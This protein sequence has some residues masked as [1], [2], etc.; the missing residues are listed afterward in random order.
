MAE[1]KGTQ[2]KKER[3]KKKLEPIT[4]RSHAH[5][6][7]TNEF[8]F[9]CIQMK[10]RQ[11]QGPQS[12]ELADWPRAGFDG[13]SPPPPPPS[14]PWWQ[15]LV[16]AACIRPAGTVPSAVRG[17]SE[18]AALRRVR[19]APA[20]SRRSVRAGRGRLEPWDGRRR[21]DGETGG[22]PTPGA[23]EGGRRRRRDGKK[24][25]PAATNPNS[26]KVVT[27]QEPGGATQISE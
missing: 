13:W 7:N 16:T 9:Y 6:K 19:E 3:K 25:Q 11:K 2:R 21:R 22:E 23:S 14:L 18:D 8:V 1:N 5:R 15:V 27:H 4:K 12:N 26:V 10:V 17:Q 20:R 24:Q